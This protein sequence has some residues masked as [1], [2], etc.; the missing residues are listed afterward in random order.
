MT[1]YYLDN[2]TSNIGISRFTGGTG[3]GRGLG[4]SGGLGGG[5]RN[6]STPSSSSSSSIPRMMKSIM[7]LTT[8]ITAVAF[9]PS[10]ELVMHDP[11]VT[12]C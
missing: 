6:H 2:I 9:H 4:G 11:P 7:N 10:G 8:K 1:L 5:G 12:R 3:G